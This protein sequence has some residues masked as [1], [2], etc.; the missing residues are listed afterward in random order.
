MPTLA[1]LE[2]VNN[3]IKK[4]KLIRLKAKIEVFIPN[5]MDIVTQWSLK[6]DDR[7]YCPIKDLI[8]L[9]DMTKGYQGLQ[10]QHPANSIVK[11]RTRY[12]V[13]SSSSKN[14]SPH[15]NLTEMAKDFIR[16]QRMCQYKTFDEWATRKNSVY[17]LRRDE[18]IEV[19]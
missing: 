6:N 1:G 18:Q 10:E 11:I 2:A 14:I 3:D 13:M 19:D 15:P 5:A 12:Y 8:S 17:E 7:L 16:V 4:I 9:P